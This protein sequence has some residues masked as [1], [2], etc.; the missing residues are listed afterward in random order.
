MPN[1]GEIEEISSAS[2]IRGS[3]L[4]PDVKARKEAEQLSNESKRE[5]IR[6]LKNDND[7]RV[8][9]ANSI[10][11]LVSVWLAAILLVLLLQGFFGKEG[12]PIEITN[13]MYGP[14]LYSK[15]RF[16]LP[17]EVIL[18]LIGGTTASVL[19]IF[20]FVARY[21]FPDRK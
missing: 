4:T 14:A 10:F 21:L 13:G 3:E 11:K 16:D 19:G 1:P 20:T 17:P 5:E 6:G 7:A 8:K 2:E 18:A 12:I 9:Y 15:L